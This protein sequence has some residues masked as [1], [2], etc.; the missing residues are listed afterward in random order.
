MSGFEITF[1]GRFFTN[2]IDFVFLIFFIIFSPN[3]STAEVSDDANL[4]DI[5][6][7][8]SGDK[9]IAG[10]KIG[11]AKVLPGERTVLNSDT[12]AV[13]EESTMQTSTHTAQPS[14]SIL[15]REETAGVVDFPAA[16]KEVH[17]YET[18]GTENNELILGQNYM[19]MQN[20]TL[21]KFQISI[22]EKFGFG[23]M[24]NLHL[25]FDFDFEFWG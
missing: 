8:L 10:Y 6:A 22:F 20:S 4:M 25:K 9:N 1:S 11:A 17:N 2:S 24:K 19:K 18:V 15:D 23:K 3:S 14:E 7:D 5:P 21:P 13:G 16:P 12:A